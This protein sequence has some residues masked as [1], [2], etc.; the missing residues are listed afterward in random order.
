MLEATGPG[1][2]LATFT[3]ATASALVDGTDPVTY[4]L[5]SGSTFA[6][7]TT[8]VTLTATDSHH[9]SSTATF[10]TTVVDTTPPVIAAH[11]HVTAESTTAAGATVSFTA[12]ATADAVD[13]PGVATLSP[14]S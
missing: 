6:F 4:S 13:C 1:G 12:S 11:A 7:G 2:A 9:N 3:G 8:T 5:A 10:T 14:A